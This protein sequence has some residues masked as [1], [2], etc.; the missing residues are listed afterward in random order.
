MAQFIS[1]DNCG[2]NGIIKGEGRFF[3]LL[4]CQHKVYLIIFSVGYFVLFFLFTK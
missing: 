4:L 3:F 2:D 1:L